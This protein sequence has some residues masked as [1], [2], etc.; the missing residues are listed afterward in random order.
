MMTHVSK[1]KKVENVT[2]PYAF[3]M[4][5]GAF[6]SNNYFHTCP[7]VFHGKDDLGMPLPPLWRRILEDDHPLLMDHPYIETIVDNMY[8]PDCITETTLLEI[9]KMAY[10]NKL[11]A[12]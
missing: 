10:I 11:R 9:I 6:I 12:E 2:T 7:R 4:T 5:I 8:R 1:M 3:F